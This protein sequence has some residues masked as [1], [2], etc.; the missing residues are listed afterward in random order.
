MEIKEKV[1]GLLSDTEIENILE[2]GR[3]KSV[4]FCEAALE[5]GRLGKGLTLVELAALAYCES[6][7]IVTGLLDTAHE[8]KKRIYG[9]RMVFFAPLY[10]SSFCSN[11][12]TYCGFR[13]ANETMT[14]R[15]LSPEEIHQEVM[16][17][18]EQGHKRLLLVAGEDPRT[19]GIDYL[20]QSVAAVYS[21]TAP[22]GATIRR[23]NV[24]C[25]PLSVDHFRRL[26]ATGI[27]TYQCFQET[28]HRPTYKEVHPSGPKSHYDWRITAPDR[29]MEADIDDIGTGVLFGLYD[30]HFDVVGLLGHARYLET[31]FDVGPHTISVPRL[32][33][34]EGAPLSDHSPW[35]VSDED[36]RKIVALLRVAVPYTGM[37]L[38]TRESPELRDQLFAL[39]ISQTSAGSRVTPGGYTDSGKLTRE[40]LLAQ[41]SLQDQRPLREMVHTFVRGDY[42]PSFCTA[43]YRSGR[44]G[45][46]FMQLAKSGKIHDICQP[47]ALASL[48]E[49]LLDYADEETKA[50]GEKLIQKELS[51][52][53]ERLRNVTEKMLARVAAGERDVYL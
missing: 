46:R 2:E 18:L 52:L 42:I 51:E 48:K 7:E 3:S 36:F 13:H 41:F 12:C 44:T 43:C 6:P 34:A 45:D 14:R 32:E 21:V 10:I 40:D 5:N 35:M 22:D 16:A 1:Y 28:Y 33:P 31:K 38:S 17:L 39:G 15:S 11:N 49:Y 9:E 26:K 30:W 25:A 53:P 50:Q 4:E 27:G 23:A 37:I 29:A 24:N 47:N 20:E 19:T 8:L